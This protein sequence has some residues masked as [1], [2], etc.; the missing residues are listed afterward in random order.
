MKKEYTPQ[1]SDPGTL[2][3]FVETVVIPARY[4]N[5]SSGSH[6]TRL[7]GWLRKTLR[8]I[9]TPADLNRQTFDHFVSAIA[10][11]GVTDEGQY[12]LRGAFI[13]LWKDAR[14]RGCD[15]PP[16]DVLSPCKLRR[17]GEKLAV[18]EQAAA[19]TAAGVL[20]GEICE[21]L[22]IKPGWLRDARN[23]HHEAWSTAAGEAL[24]Q[25]DESPLSS[26]SSLNDL[27]RRY[28]LVGRRKP[29]APDT[30]SKM[31]AL[32]K[33]ATQVLGRSPTVADLTP[34]FLKKFKASWN[35]PTTA[36]C[37]GA[38]LLSL[39]RFAEEL[40]LVNNAPP[41]KARVWKNGNDPRNRG[42]LSEKK[43]TL[44]HLCLSTYF[45]VNMSIRA[46]KTKEMYRVSLKDF[47]DTLGHEP[48]KKDLTDDNLSKMM[49]SLIARGLAPKTVNERAARIKA[50]WNWMAK[51][52][53]IRHFPT[54]Q[55]VREPKRTPKAWTRDDL[56]TILAACGRERGLI[57]GIP[58]ATFWKALL[59]TLWDSGARIGEI[60]AIRWEW[61]NLETGYVNIPAEVRKGGTQDMAYVLHADTLALIKS[62]ASPAR[63][64]VFSWP[65]CEASLY[66]HYK[67]ILKNA[68]LPCGRKDKFHKIRRSVASH[69][70]AGGHNAS[71]V[72][73]HSS[74]EVTKA[75]YL[76][77]SIVGM[78]SPS[79]VL[80]R[81][82][83]QQAK[84]KVD[85]PHLVVEAI[86]AEDW[87]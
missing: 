81:P 8:R 37:F 63:E 38:M 40:C 46:Q 27:V 50:L 33:R 2:I 66:L 7:C 55:N 80:F 28:S 31:R 21:R 25:I 84:L 17:R 11:M 42:D 48:T 51:R 58:A 75:S 24:K 19:L 43:G 56:A 62:M 64:R 4:R 47:R 69:L 26:S 79:A 45:K 34:E 22:N 74:A 52:Q 77:P 68:G 15:V 73:G 44:W 10:T 5:R 9:P 14:Q 86:A 41:R 12:S 3:H 23:L 82:D 54:T 35:G 29:P 61:L 83:G 87:L 60:L 49:N 13:Q 78:V 1:P 6:F 85:P 32:L 20:R 18:I 76:D 71:Q 53:I 65:L 16:C 57:A 67:S 70:Q 36:A 39:W 72:L 30:I 59:M